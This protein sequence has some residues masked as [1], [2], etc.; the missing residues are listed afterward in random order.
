MK[1]F[2]T[3]FVFLFL[4]ALRSG[5]ADKAAK[6]NIIYILADDLGFGNVS[7]YGAD[8]FKTPRIDALAK[9]GIRFQH[10]FAQPL[11]GPSRAQILTGRYAFRTGMTGN[12]SGSL[13]K[14]ENETM[15]PKV[16]KPAG[17]V[18]AQ[19]GKWSQ[20]PLQ[21]GDFGFDEYLRFPG[22]GAYWSSQA[23]GKTYSL[24]GQEKKLGDKYMPDVMHDFLID[25]I[26][27]HRD[28]PFYVHYAM[29]HVHGEILRTPDSKPDSKDFYSDNIAYMD[30]LVGKLVDE[31]DRLKLR[32][33]T[34]LIFVGDNGTAK[35]AFERSP[36]NGKMISGHKGQM[37]EG[38]SLVPMI[39]NWPGTTPSGKVSQELMDFSDYLPTF[40]ELAGANLPKNVTIDGH[41]FASQ[42]RGGKEA[43]PRDWIFVEL[44]K[45]WYVREMNWKLN[46]VGELFD[47]H[48]APFEEKLV[49]VGS[50]NAEAKSA[51]ARLQKVLDEL[52]PAAGKRDTGDG[53][54]KSAKK[55]KRARQSADV[56]K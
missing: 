48:G 51:R 3:V 6:P 4:T 39:A 11:C 38:G 32:E 54:G 21:P 9:G 7:C 14:P 2:L 31:L 19:I 29:S 53:S 50:E 43:K 23:R 15:L 42:L 55:A 45:H 20:L 17:Y 47:M 28:Q 30:K 24:S 8:N 16:L 33:N 10:C 5:A 36:V 52:N 27:R 22:S 25:F 12:G 35:G 41:S 37:L 18:S 46:E 49:A 56:A 44:G 40:A 34:L 1:S 13:I 26:K